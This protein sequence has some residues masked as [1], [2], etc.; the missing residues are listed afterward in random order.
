[1]WAYLFKWRYEYSRE[2]IDSVDIAEES[3]EAERK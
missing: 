1:M 3:N 2:G